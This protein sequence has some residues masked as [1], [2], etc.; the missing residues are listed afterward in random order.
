LHGPQYHIHK[1][2]KKI[3]ILRTKKLLV[4]RLPFAATVHFH[5]KKK[6]QADCP[7]KFF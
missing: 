4:K 7:Q 5:F 6:E 3:K 1:D 2:E